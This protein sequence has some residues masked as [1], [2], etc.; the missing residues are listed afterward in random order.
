MN[1]HG[2][3]TAVSPI[4]RGRK[5]NFFDATLA[6]SSG[7]MRVVGFNMQQQHLPDELHKASLPVELGN[8]EVK[9][10]RQGYGYNLL[11]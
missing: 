1:I 7:T 2:A 9:H 4:K 8:C 10:S 5:S 6:D 11:L 3:I